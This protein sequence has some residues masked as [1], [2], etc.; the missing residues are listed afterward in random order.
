MVHDRR[1]AGPAGPRR[2]RVLVVA[3]TRMP[4]GQARAALDIVQG[5][6]RHRMIDATILAIDPRLAGSLRFLTEWK[7]IRSVV[8]PALYLRRLI[9]AAART[10]VFH[11][12]CAAH[13]AFLF[14]A[15]P[16][17]LVATWFRRPVVLNY[18]DGRAAAHLRW[19][20]P[21]LRWAIRRAAMLVFPS[22]YL[23]ELFRQR[24]FEG[25]VVPNVVDSSAVACN[26][27]DHLPRR[28]ISARLL[29]PLYAVEN[30]LQAFALV[31]AEMPDVVCDVYGAGSAGH[32]LKRVAERLG[33]EGIRFHGAI[34]HSRML[35]IL[36]AGGI[37][38]NSSR[39]DNMP[40][41]V[42]EAWAAGVPVVTTAVGGI[43]Y[44][45]EHDRTGL[46]VPVDR[47]EA[48][49]AAALRV[50]R[51]PGLAARLIE[52]GR[53]ECRRYG[54][55]AAERGWLQVYRQAAGAARPIPQHTRSGRL[56]I[57]L[58]TRCSETEA[59]R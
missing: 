58:P 31:R 25:V 52:A 36:A 48:L 9:R 43:P 53:R 29:E 41:V 54:W 40:H 5:F 55:P 39:A 37:L 12:F 20:G 50:L 22:P 49:A 27:Q 42:M 47:P 35:S 38:V 30:I 34:P 18:H 10:D 21:V 33:N 3:P 19:W 16:A 4:G 32:A 57:P 28:L 59:T 45:V 23:Q 51:E 1:R 2:L 11:V 44:L 8:R 17:V 15:A 24:G 14:G 13:T 7:G 46:L 56:S 6:A 26:A